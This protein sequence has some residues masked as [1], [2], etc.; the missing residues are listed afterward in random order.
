[1]L[2][3]L[4]CKCT[5]LGGGT[6]KEITA[7]VDILNL[8]IF[9]AELNKI[10]IDLTLNITLNYTTLNRGDILYIQRDDE[11][12]IK[13]NRIKNI[14]LDPDRMYKIFKAEMVI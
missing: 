9:N 12:L 10:T 1:M 3:Y 2:N 13:E 4:F 7:S 6:T 11:F 8:E 14:L 5:C